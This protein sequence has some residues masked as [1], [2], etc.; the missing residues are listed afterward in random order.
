MVKHVIAM[1][2]LVVTPGGGVC[3]HKVDQV[4]AGEGQ[5]TITAWSQVQADGA[6]GSPHGAL[7]SGA[8][9]GVWT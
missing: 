8:L 6:I 3:P 2:G 1:V 9:T 4:Q 5:F 7:H